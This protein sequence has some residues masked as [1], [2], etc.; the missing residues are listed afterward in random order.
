MKPVVNLLI[1]AFIAFFYMFS[2][3]TRPDVPFWPTMTVSAAVLA[4]FSLLLQRKQLQEIYA[5]ESRH[6]VNGVLAAFILYAVFWAGFIISTKTLP[7]AELQVNSIYGIRDEQNP[8][9]IAGLLMFIIGPAEEIF[10]RGFIQQRLSKKYGL[11]FGFIA[12]AALY[13]LVHIWSF[14]FMLIAAA[15]LC[16]G[17]WGLLYLRTGSLWTCII[18]HAVWDVVI[19]VLFPIK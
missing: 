2:S 18:S 12:A 11:W 3:T 13:T 4:T 5:F 1:V 15:A 10:W 19:F 7:F 8:W 9:L 6:I 14:N 16:G 17:F